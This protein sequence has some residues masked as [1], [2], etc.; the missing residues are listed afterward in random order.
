[1]NVGKS[2]VM[3]CTRIEDGARLN[4]M[5]NGE[6]LEVDQFQY[7]GSVIAALD[8]VGG[9]TVSSSELLTFSSS[10]SFFPF[11][12][13]G[14]CCPSAWLYAKITYSLGYSSKWWSGS[15]CAS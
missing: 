7:L 11:A 4:V 5:L 3:R 8:V 10:C 1:M 13:N 15:R 12:L 14:H 9:L 2:K 6:A